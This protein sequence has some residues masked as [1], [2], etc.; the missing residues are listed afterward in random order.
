VLHLHGTLAGYKQ[1]VPGHRAR[2]Y[3]AFDAVTRPLPTLRP[4]QIVVST[5]Q[6]A[7]EVEAYGLDMD[8]V[9]V[10]PMGIDPD[11]YRFEDERREPEQILFVGRL[12][13]DRNVEQVLHALGLIRDL[14]WS[15]KIV[16]GEERRSYASRG[17]YVAKLKQ[18]AQDLGIA[19]RVCF[20][21]PLYGEELRRTYA[22][23]G[24]FA[25]TSRYEN[26]GQTILEAAAAGCA[27]VTSATGVAAEIVEEGVSG[28][29][30]P[31]D[32]PH[33]L[34]SRLG[35]LL[36]NPGRAKAL[37]AKASDVVKQRF[38]WRT[39]S[40]QYIELYRDLALRRETPLISPYAAAPTGPYA[41]RSVGNQVKS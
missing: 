25:Y 21:G 31:L 4:D 28:A 38:H 22:R 30:V 19:D 34:A 27:L 24:I 1:I 39:I 20:T 32:D 36:G 5:H 15:C 13:E 2:M 7:R 16:G 14:S 33:A 17:G 29:L 26:F 12:A 3:D 8:R 6:E 9:R 23:A 41:G 37:G 11:L 18:L 40:G 35:D 10:I